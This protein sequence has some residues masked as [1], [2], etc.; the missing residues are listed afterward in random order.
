MKKTVMG[1]VKG[2]KMIELTAEVGGK[3]LVD[4][5]SAARKALASMDKPTLESV[6]NA[7]VTTCPVPVQEASLGWRE[8]SEAGVAVELKL[9]R[10]TATVLVRQGTEWRRMKVLSADLEP[11]RFLEAPVLDE[12][13]G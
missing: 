3:Q 1:L 7:V 5:L 11:T 2:K 8:S 9:P 4:W 10:G 12:L 6:A 13:L